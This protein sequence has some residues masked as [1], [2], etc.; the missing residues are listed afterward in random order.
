VIGVGRQRA[1]VPDLRKLVVG[2][3]AIGIA[4]QVGDVGAVVLSQA[5][6]N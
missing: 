2:E 5:L 3:L 1:L 6:S 4:D